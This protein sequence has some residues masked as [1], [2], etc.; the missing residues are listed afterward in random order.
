MNQK[1]AIGIIELSSI[2]KG[3]EVQDDVLQ[4][5]Q[6]EK[7]VARTI[8]SGK[9][10]IVVRGEIADVESCLEIAKST[11]GYAIINAII[12]PNVDASI[13]PAISGATTLDS[14]KVD[15]LLIIETFSVAS[16]I[17]AADY[18]VKEADVL[19]LRIHVA[20]AIGGKGLVVVTGSIDALKSALVPAIAYVK[21]E[22]MLVGYSLI[23]DPHEDV[24][25]ELI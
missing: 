10:V 22:G 13:F 11:G 23:S 3:F 6:V 25:R 16:A 21:E 17:K 8:C 12:I 19:L 20:M 5:T 1:N 2:H 9:Y 18:V 7:L 24:L 14:P 15:G 4:N